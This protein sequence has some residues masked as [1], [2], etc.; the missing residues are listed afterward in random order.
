M[1]DCEQDRTQ[2]RA[3]KCMQKFAQTRTVRCVE[4]HAFHAIHILKQM[5]AHKK[6]MER[7]DRQAASWKPGGLERNSK[8]GD[9]CGQT[10]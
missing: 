5:H 8:C 6:F 10:A 9:P 2:M 3:G 7:I 4:V 1:E